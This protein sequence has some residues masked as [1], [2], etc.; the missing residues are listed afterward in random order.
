MSSNQMFLKHKIVFLGDQSVG[1]TSIILRFSQDTYDGKQKA[2]VGIDFLTK[3]IYVD[4]KMVR[5]QIWDTA[6]QERF[7]TLT[8]NFYRRAD[9]IIV[10]FDV[11]DKKTFDAVSTWMKAIS[12]HADASADV[13]LCGNKIDLVD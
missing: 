13:V 6:G 1:K 5:M 12:D 8:T 9:G 11:T 2:T 3:T 10:S 4:D 7:R